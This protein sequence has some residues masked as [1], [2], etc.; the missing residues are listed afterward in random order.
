MIARFSAAVATPLGAKIAPQSLDPAHGV[1]TRRGIELATGDWILVV[2]ADEVITATLAER[3]RAHR[4][5]TLPRLAPALVGHGMRR[6]WA[7]KSG[8]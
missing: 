4:R 3:L 2:D 5:G 8:R 6:L 1:G 7:R